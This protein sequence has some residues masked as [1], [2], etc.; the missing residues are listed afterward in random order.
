[1]LYFE[2]CKLM[3]I[4]ICIDFFFLMLKFLNY[5]KIKLYKY[6]FV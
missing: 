6:K 2:V 5:L 4:F 3:L 1:M